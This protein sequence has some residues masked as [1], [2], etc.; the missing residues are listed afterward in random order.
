M[1]NYYIY[2]IKVTYN[3]YVRLLIKITDLYKCRHSLINVGVT[4]LQR[5][6][7]NQSILWVINR[8]ILFTLFTNFIHSMF[9]LSNFI[10]L[11]HSI[12]LNFDL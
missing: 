8:L 4:S 11:T 1:I 2:F 3:F 12:P 6:G 5:Y 9:I 7:V 10:L